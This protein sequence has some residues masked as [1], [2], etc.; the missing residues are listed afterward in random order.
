MTEQP[1]SDGAPL[2]EALVAALGQIDEA[3]TDVRNQIGKLE[4][5][6]TAVETE[7]PAGR[8]PVV[9]VA[10]SETA[11]ERLAELIGEIGATAA[12]A[13]SSAAQAQVATAAETLRVMVVS[14]IN[15]LLDEA[16][17]AAHVEVDDLAGASPPSTSQPGA[18]ET[19][20]SADRPAQ[21]PAQQPVQQPAQMPAEPTASTGMRSALGVQ[22]LKVTD[23]PA[24]PAAHATTVSAQ[25]A[26]A[27]LASDQAATNGHDDVPAPLDL[28]DLDDPFLEALAPASAS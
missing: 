15:R 5:R 3:L 12:A 10:L 13:A 16:G 1:T 19:Q 24:Q 26:N 7:Q 28:D 14:E 11:Q 21:E 22:G 18:S 27:Q 17:I 6:M 4:V 2:G 20:E 8:A 25:K 9:E 23:A